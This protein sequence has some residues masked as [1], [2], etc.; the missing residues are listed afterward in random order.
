MR[1]TFLGHAGLFIETNGGS[2][3]CDPWFSPAFFASWFPFPRNDAL[4]V[5]GLLNP[6]YLY[7]SH[8]HLDHFDAAFLSRVS[9]HTTVLLPDFPLADHETA[10]RDLGF[11][12]MVRCANGAPVDLGGLRVAIDADTDEATGD[13]ML[14]VDD[15]QCR[16]LNQNDAR[17][18]SLGCALAFGPFDAHFLQF[19]GAM[20]Y[21]AIYR[22][23]AEVKAKLAARTRASQTQ[24]ALRHIAEIGAKE[25]FPCAGPPCFLDEPLFS[26][27]DLDSSRPTIFPDQ[28]SFLAR[29]TEQGAD[30]GHLIF[31]GSLVEVSGSACDVSHPAPEDDLRNECFT[32]KAAYLERYARD[33][34]PVLAA[35]RHE[36]RPQGLD[37]TTE[38]ADWFMPLMAGADEVCSG[39]GS[40][41]LLSSGDH[42]IL[43][44]FPRREVRAA[45]STSEA[46]YR[47]F[48]PP[49]L[50]E[51]LVQAR[52]TDWVNS[53]F[54][55]CRLEAE[56]D[57]GYNEWLYT[58]FKGLSPSRLR[59][60]EL[61]YST[62]PAAEPDWECAGYLIQ[63]RCPH[64]KADLQR[65]AV[66]DGDTL[67]CTMHGWQFD[68]RTGR[69]LTA[70]GRVLR[71]TPL[72]DG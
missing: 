65:F 28:A 45:V 40:C 29:M 61:V 46:G 20:W 52:T 44:D 26:L 8:S 6:D 11:V 68:L 42:Q 69:C 60:L 19:S 34:E 3:L 35:F 72:A 12:R 16:V 36:M 31:P 62:P 30:N 48:V 37:L 27:N 57:N 56:R 10:L 39:I 38:I 51:A 47:F 63:R 23:P 50:L 59:H 41:V 15:G 25:V 7:V 66:V 5:S 53:L 43:L 33:M 17:P 21:P 14:M 9:P 32:N 18:L 54:L 67:T 24:R 49:E 71:S 1:I 22:W 13:S 64:F 4:D 2:I 70:E 58:F 55:S